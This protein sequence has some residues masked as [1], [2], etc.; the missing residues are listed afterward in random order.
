MLNQ[1]ELHNNASIDACAEVFVSPDKAKAF[2]VITPPDGG[3]TL[4]LENILN[5][6]VKNGVVG[7]LIKEAI[8]NIVKLSLI[9]I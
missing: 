8:E 7:G 3:R 2:I 4:T 5:I 6:L 9:H 1:E